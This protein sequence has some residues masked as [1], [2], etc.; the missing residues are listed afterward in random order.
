MLRIIST[1]WVK[2][3]SGICKSNDDTVQALSPFATQNYHNLL[4]SEFFR[5]IPYF[6]FYALYSTAH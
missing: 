2:G 4:S 1:Q 6:L 5:N 3:L